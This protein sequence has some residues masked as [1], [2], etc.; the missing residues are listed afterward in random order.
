MAFGGAQTNWNPGVTGA[1]SATLQISGL[2]LGAWVTA[3]PTLADADWGGLSTATATP[4][5]T[6]AIPTGFGKGAGNWTQADVNNINVSVQDITVGASAGTVP[7]TH[8]VS[9]SLV[10]SDLSIVIH[11]ESATASTGMIIT[12]TY[13]T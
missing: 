8:L 7:D 2:T 12:L 5:N 10:G 11:N 1:Q 3:T 9:K 13:P 4:T 6:N